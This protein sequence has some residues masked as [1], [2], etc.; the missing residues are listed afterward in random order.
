MCHMSYVYV[1]IKMICL[2]KD[3]I[4]FNFIEPIKIVRAPR[5]TMVTRGSLARFD[6][7]IKLDPTLDVTV[8]WLKDKKFLILGRR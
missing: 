6:C 8:T 3:Y 5:N 4:Y 1:Y 7:K 2:L